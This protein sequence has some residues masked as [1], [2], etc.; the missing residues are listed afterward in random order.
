MGPLLDE[1]VLCTHT[2][3]YCN[4]CVVV[5]TLITCAYL[6]AQVTMGGI[7]IVTQ[8]ADSPPSPPG[9]KAGRNNTII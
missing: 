6:E 7:G 3:L 1:L 5:R 4:N 9:A 2:T 8:G